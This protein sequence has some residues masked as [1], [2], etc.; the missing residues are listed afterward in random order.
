MF[1]ERNSWGKMNVDVVIEHLNMGQYCLIFKY[2]YSHNSPGTAQPQLR[3]SLGTA[4]PLSDHQLFCV[5]MLH[6]RISLLQQ[7]NG[8]W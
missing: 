5:Q 3:Y 7:I 1:T 4:I 8:K 6:L 2:M